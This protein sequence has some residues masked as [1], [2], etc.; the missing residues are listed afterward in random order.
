LIQTK[1]CAAK[2]FKNGDEIKNPKFAA[3]D[4]LSIEGPTL[5]TGRAFAA[6]LLPGCGI[7]R[8]FGE[9]MVPDR[10]PPGLWNKSRLRR[11][12]LFLA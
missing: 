4:Q 12:A 8:D 6:F 11:P 1:R 9:P 7:A 3:G 10:A 2:F 5:E